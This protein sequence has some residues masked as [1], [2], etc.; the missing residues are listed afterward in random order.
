MGNCNFCGWEAGFLRGKHK[1]CEAANI[2]GLQKM[3]ELAAQAINAAPDV[4]VAT[5]H[6]SLEAIAEHSFIDKQGIRSTI[7][8]AWRETVFASL[9]D[10]VLSYEEESRLRALCDRLDLAVYDTNVDPL[11]QLE[12]WEQ[13]F[14]M[15]SAR[16]LQHE[17][18]FLSLDMEG[19]T[20]ALHEALGLLMDSVD[21]DAFANYNALIQLDKAAVIREVSEGI[22]PTRF[23]VGDDLPVN[24]QKSEELVWV[25][26]GVDYYELRTRREHRGASHGVSIRIT[27]GLYYQPREFRS[28]SHEWDEKIYVDT[29][30]LGLTNKH[31]YFHGNRKRFRIRFDKIVSFEQLNDGLGLTR[32]ALTAK[33]QGFRTGDGWFVYKLVTNLAKL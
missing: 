5:L 23:K 18:W 16:R 4:D 21:Y 25:F 6:A 29:G 24:L 3:F 22:I 9:T 10:G 26:K 17:H 14:A 1:E 15:E 13:E 2:A 27:Q 31:I 33:P 19:Q 20:R 30:L 28:Q 8:Q 32:D 12:E 11:S 7:A